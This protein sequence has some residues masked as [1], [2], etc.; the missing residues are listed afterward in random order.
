MTAQKKNNF[1]GLQEMEA[2]M[3]IPLNSTTSAARPCWPQ[4]V[5]H[6]WIGAVLGNQ[7]EEGKQG[8][9]GCP[10]FMQCLG[11]EHPDPD[12]ITLVSI[13]TAMVTESQGG[14]GWKGQ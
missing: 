7:Q 9:C 1:C 5:F 3:Q 14:V 6:C 8:V 12:L 10:E 11:A 4:K 2:F 13:N